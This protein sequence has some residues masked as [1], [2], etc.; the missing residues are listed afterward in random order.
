MLWWRSWR[1]KARA[2]EKMHQGQK[3]VRD[4]R[5][6]ILSC[7]RRRFG[8]TPSMF[9]LLTVMGAARFYAAVMQLFELY[10]AKLPVA[11]YFVRYENLVAD[12]EA[13][14]RRICD[15]IGLPWTEGLR[16]FSNAEGR[17][18]STPSAGQ[19][20]RGLYATGADQ[21]RHYERHLEPVMPAIAPW[22][23]RWNYSA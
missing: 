18:S 3:I 12:F 23:S 19:V 17:S 10:S 14:T 11:P 21:W 15:F 6:V 8:M 16:D 22:I 13:E 1:N 5:D 4:P 9:E 20:K 2:L 7:Y